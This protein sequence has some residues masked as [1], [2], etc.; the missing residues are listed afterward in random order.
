LSKE[1]NNLFSFG[2]QQNKTYDY[3]DETQKTEESRV[4]QKNLS[5]CDSIAKSEEANQKNY[6]AKESLSQS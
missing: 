1:E 2:N 3:Q 5:T 6:E 4:R